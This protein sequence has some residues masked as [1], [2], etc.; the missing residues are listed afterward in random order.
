MSAFNDYCIVC[1]KICTHSS[2]YCS[3]ECQFKDGNSHFDFNNAP[4]LISPVLEPRSNSIASTLTSSSS[5]TIETDE[6]ESELEDDQQYQH[7][8]QEYLIKSPLLLSSNTKDSIAG[9]SLNDAIPREGNTNLDQHH[10]E[11][12]AASSTNYKKW[13]NVVL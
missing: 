8:H 11:L 12:L 6:I 1:D 3:D 5:S 7:K 13:L 2:V 9:L 10:I 4:Q